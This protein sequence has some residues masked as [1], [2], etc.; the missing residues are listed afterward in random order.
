M[1]SAAAG[2]MGSALLTVITTVIVVK[3][4]GNTN[5]S[6]FIL[7]QTYMY[8]VDGLI[9]F[10]SWAAVI[11]FGSERIAE[12]DDNGLQSIIKLGAIVDLTT[13]FLGMIV[14]IFLAPL[15]GH[16]FGWSEQ[17]IILSTIFSIEIIFHFS[18]TSVGVLR[19]FNH[20]NLVAIQKIS[21]A[22]LKLAISIGLLLLGKQSLL[23]FIIAYVISDVIGHILLTVMSIVII[24]KTPGISIQGIL[25]SSTVK[26]RMRFWRFAFWS[27]LATS[28]DIPVKQFDVFIMS[29]I[30]YEMVAVYKVYKQIGNILVEL[31]IPI[32]QSIMPQFSDL[33]ARRRHRECMDVVQK[34]HKSILTLLIPC[35][36]VFCLVSPKLLNI[37]FGEL[38]SKYFYIL[39]I[40]LLIRSYGLSY[41]AIHQLFTSMGLVKEDFCIVGIT[42]I[43]YVILAFVLSR[44]IGLLGVVISLGVQV[45]TCVHLKK[46][47]IQKLLSDT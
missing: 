40:Y 42:N 5:Y 8:I 33:V 24:V 26:Y 14:A 46:A 36:I 38:Y 21:V 9:N 3:I 31:S 6:T 20:F 30:S 37:F 39:I 34:L 27:N 32:S 25:H 44:T 28:I 45:F 43:I 12:N 22:F 41:T 16:I 17:L 47:L 7:A 18:G 15:V 35:A 29:A 13:S 2:E 10:Q 19:L 23:L 1:F 4:L 11:K